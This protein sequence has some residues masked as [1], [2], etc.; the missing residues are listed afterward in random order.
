[1]PAWKWRDVR[2]VLLAKGFRHERSTDHE[3]YRF[4]RDGRATSVRTKI[5]HGNRGELHSAS[6]LMREIQRQLHLR[7]EDLEDLLD[8]PMSE[9]GYAATLHEHGLLGK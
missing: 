7:R 9:D 8:C 2:R 6:P 3:Y 1:M 5:S 4:Y